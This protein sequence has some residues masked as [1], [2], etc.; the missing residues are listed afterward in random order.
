MPGRVDGGGYTFTDKKLYGYS[1]THVSGPGCL[2]AGDVPILP[3]TGK[4][5]AGEPT[6]ITTAFSHSG[7]IAQA[8]YY[9]AR[10]NG[11]ATITSDLAPAAHAAIGSFTFPRT[12]SADLL[13]KL[14]GQPAGRRSP[15]TSR[16]SAPMRCPAPSPAATSATS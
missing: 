10:S 2:A 4:L 11:S 15:R 8:G 12:K 5:P 14:Q 3:M 6:N 13:I 16:R 9:S 1:L 7:E